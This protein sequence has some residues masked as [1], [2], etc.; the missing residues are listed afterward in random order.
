MGSKLQGLRGMKYSVHGIETEVL[1]VG[2]L[3]IMQY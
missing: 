1:N 3:E 2:W